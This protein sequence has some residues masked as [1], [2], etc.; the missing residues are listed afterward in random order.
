MKLVITNQ[1]LDRLEESLEF[2]IEELGF[3]LEKISDIKKELLDRAKSLV[4]YPYM[5]Q[6]EPY[7]KK[8]DKGYRRLVVGNFKII[9]RIDN[10]TVYVTDFFDSHKDP[11]KMKGE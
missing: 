10:D 1:S 5:G 9:Y 2:Y 7:L 8:L 4:V 11:S 3:P 6:Y